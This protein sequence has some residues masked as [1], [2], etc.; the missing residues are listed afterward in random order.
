[1]F[2]AAEQSLKLALAG[3]RPSASLPLFSPHSGSRWRGQTGTCQT[4]SP[5]AH[6]HRGAGGRRAAAARRRK[7][8]LAAFTHPCRPLRCPRRR[9]P[10][11]WAGRSALALRTLRSRQP[12]PRRA[13]PRP[14]TPRP[15]RGGRPRG[16][17]CAGLG[18]WGRGGEPR[19]RP[20]RR[21]APPEPRACPSPAPRVA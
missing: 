19:R 18:G 13:S 5:S 11:P 14:A 8:A 6:R 1:M 15:R 3:P 10:S 4:R 17:L 9:L 20:S 12:A 21:A 2:T 16:R 7:V